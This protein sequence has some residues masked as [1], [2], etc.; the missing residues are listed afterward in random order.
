[1]IVPDLT[2]SATPTLIAGLQ[3]HDPFH[4]RS[5]ILELGSRAAREAVAPLI[6]LLVSPTTPWQVAGDAATALGHIGDLTAVAPLITMLNTPLIAGHAVE[7]LAQLH[8][9]VALAALIDYFNHT[10][11]ASVAT[12]LGNWRDPRAVDALLGAVQ[13]PD[14]H[15]RFYSV[16]A[17]G[18]IADARAIPTL[19]Q[20]IVTDTSIGVFPGSRHG[21]SV[22]EAAKKALQQISDHMKGA[23]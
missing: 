4:Q 10:Q 21:T 16:R 19:E 18:K 23:P 1:M 13:H 11:N 22:S 6:T 12:I 15:V 5:A 9:D 20:V 17:L 3:H 14:S 8:T 7:A 2:G